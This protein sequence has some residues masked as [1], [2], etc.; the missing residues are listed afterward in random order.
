MAKLQCIRHSWDFIFHLRS[1]SPIQ[2][3]HFAA[4]CSIT[5]PPATATLCWGRHLRPSTQGQRTRR[6][7]G[8]GPVAATVPSPVRLRAEGALALNGFA[9]AAKTTSSGARRV[10]LRCRPSGF[11]GAAKT[12]SGEAR[13]AAARMALATTAKTAW[14]DGDVHDRAQ[15]AE[16]ESSCNPSHSVKIR[17]CTRNVLR[18]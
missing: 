8:E 1:A 18:I 4:P 13:R 6:S 2:A 3:L 14:E 15:E 17:H 12:V 7:Q 10:A 9:G 16:R 11:R 5:R